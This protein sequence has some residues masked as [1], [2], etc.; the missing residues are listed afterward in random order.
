MLP[1]PT[2]GSR[3]PTTVYLAFDLSGSM[4]G[5][6]LAAAQRAAEAFVSQ[7]DLTTTSVGLIA[8]SDSVR[9]ELQASQNATEIGQA[10]AGLT[11]GLTGGGNDGHPF[12]DLH[13]LM[14]GRDGRRYALVLADG[15]WY[16]QELAVRK[17]KRCHKDGIE[18][19][20]IG[21]GSA[22]RLFLDRIA[23]STEQ[24]FFTDLNKL[25]QAFST[26][27]RELT[28]GT[29]ARSAAIRDPSS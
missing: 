29:G 18:V 27:A 7:L 2:V 12:D 15:V 23:S 6:P 20:A 8:F 26:I 10:I 16:C 5:Q 17:A 28:E 22:D 3:G 1:P 19:I 13:R 9:V 21:F 11:I 24:V 4:Y 25:T 14:S